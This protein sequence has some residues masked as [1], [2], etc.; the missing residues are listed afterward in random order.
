MSSILNS[1]D[2]DDIRA[3]SFRFRV[4]FLY[5]LQLTDNCPPESIPKISPNFFAPT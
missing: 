4:F 5:V 3:D 2:N 1:G